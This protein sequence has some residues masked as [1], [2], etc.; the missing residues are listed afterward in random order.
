MDTVEESI[1]YNPIP[2]PAPDVLLGA[3]KAISAFVKDPLDAVESIYDKYGPFAGIVRGEDARKLPP[4]LFAL[5]PD[6]FPE[7]NDTAA[8][9]PGA[10]KFYPALGADADLASV[11]VDNLRFVSRPALLQTAF[12][13][14]TVD[15]LLEAALPLTVPIV[16]HWERQLTTE[17]FDVV[18]EFR[19]VA[20]PIA[21][22]AVF[23]F[24]VDDVP[25]R[26][27]DALHAVQA[28]GFRISGGSALE[29][30]VGGD[31]AVKI[32]SRTLTELASNAHFA[33]GEPNLVGSLAAART[34]DGGQFTD[35]DM[36]AILAGV[37]PALETA[38]WSIA[39]WSC[40]LI[41]QQTMLLAKI[42]DELYTITKGNRIE[43][44][45]VGQLAV[46]DG[47]VRETM[48]LF[49]TCPIGSRVTLAEVTLGEWAL[50]PGALL[51]HSPFVTQRDAAVYDKPGRFLPHRFGV[52]KPT[53]NEWLPFG[54]LEPMSE[55]AVALIKLVLGTI[56][57]RFRLTML[58]GQTVNHAGATALIPVGPVPMYVVSPGLIYPISHVSGSIHSFVELPKSK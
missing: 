44:A 14:S 45:H 56:F 12:D 48:R 16:D 23:G 52:Y 39:T 19:R 3:R 31:K 25:A 22:Q 5:G 40:V 27:A 15:R 36:R 8:Y 13:A 28:N 54:D 46:L 51:V 35:Q 9:G 38:L 58:R 33:I 11:A 50:P 30:L 4:M 29:R 18:A 57:Q 47:V 10:G 42:Q 24:G 2:G 53:G 21:L 43:A 37:Y 20:R 6:I 32:A 41:S 7:I 17:P 26:I 49:P 55:L 1:E 34:E